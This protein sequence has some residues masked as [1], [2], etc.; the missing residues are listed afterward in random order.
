VLQVAEGTILVRVFTPF[1]RER[2]LIL[3]SRMLLK[4]T[5]LVFLTNNVIRK[6]NFM[7]TFLLCFAQ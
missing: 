6:S 7:K 5:L 4:N 3:A 2:S 1:A